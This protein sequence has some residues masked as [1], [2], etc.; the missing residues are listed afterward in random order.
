MDILAMDVDGPPVL[1]I[2]RTESTDR[3]AT[4][5]LIGTKSNKAAIGAGSPSLP[6]IWCR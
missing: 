5:R 3:A 1:L 4:F 6:V 2:N